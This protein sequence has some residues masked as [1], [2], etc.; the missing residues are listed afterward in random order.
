M[1]ESFAGS[2]FYSKGNIDICE[3]R[4]LLSL[5]EFIILKKFP[6]MKYEA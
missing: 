2:R 5:S 4:G 1:R 3:A 6:E